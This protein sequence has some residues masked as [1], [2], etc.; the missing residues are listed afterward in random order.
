[1]GAMP[2]SA[3]KGIQ[4]LLTAER[5]CDSVESGMPSWMLSVAASTMSSKFN[6]FVGLMAY[7]DSAGYA[8]TMRL[9]RAAVLLDFCIRVSAGSCFTSRECLV[10]EGGALFC[11]GDLVTPMELSCNSFRFGGLLYTGM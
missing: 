9:A 4:Y 6:M 1:M 5:S 2:T 8:V 3:Q 11:G 10:T 7:G